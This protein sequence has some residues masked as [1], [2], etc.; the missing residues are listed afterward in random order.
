MIMIVV[1]RGRPWSEI[2]TCARHSSWVTF[3]FMYRILRLLT[4]DYRQGSAGRASCVF[5]RSWGFSDAYCKQN[6]VLIKDNGDACLTNFGLLGALEEGCGAFVAVALVNLGSVRWMAPEI[7]DSE[8]I[9][10]ERGTVSKE[11]DCHSF[12]MLILEVGAYMR[13]P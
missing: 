3:S 10:K 12:G 7:Y 13:H 6:S 5:R 4:L 2:F 1:A 8:L 11:A 9:G